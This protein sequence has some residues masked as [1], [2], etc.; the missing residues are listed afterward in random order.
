MANTAIAGAPTIQLAR[1]QM[2][3]ELGMIE[4][5][6]SQASLGTKDPWAAFLRGTICARADYVDAAEQFF[7]KSQRFGF[8]KGYEPYYRRAANL[9]RLGRVEEAALIWDLGL[10]QS[11]EM[12]GN[13]LHFGHKFNKEY[14][15]FLPLWYGPPRPIQQAVCYYC[16]G[17]YKDAINLL[18]PVSITAG[19]TPELFLWFT[20]SKIRQEK[21]VKVSVSIEPPSTHFG[22]M[23]QLI[24]LFT[25]SDQNEV[26]SL[27][28][29]LVGHISQQ[30]DRAD[31]M[32]LQ[33]F[34]A[35]Y[36]DA[37]ERDQDLKDK[38]LADLR[39][40]DREIREFNVYIAR[41]QL[42]KTP[43]T[44]LRLAS[45]TYDANRLLLPLLT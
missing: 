27:L 45:P 36:C 3:E 21:N 32:D 24:E 6:E 14:S 26:K 30:T 34:L 44:S 28:S 4:D 43:D 40:E 22:V 16:C 11:T 18:G 35:L 13:L 10:L 8:N 9:F 42:S 7:D 37:H 20:A 1:D 29:N 38:L 39:S 17:R 12:V 31:A 15:Q 5:W 41:N 33:L 25:E 2:E 23:T 19:V